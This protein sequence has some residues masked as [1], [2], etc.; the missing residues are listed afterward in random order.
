VIREINRI[1]QREIELGGDGTTASWHDDYKGMY[2]LTESG[3]KLEGTK[4]TFFIT[5]SAY[6]FVGG[7]PFELTEGDVITVMSQ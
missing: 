6:V 4:A 1:N 7:L 2:T 3:E 5:D